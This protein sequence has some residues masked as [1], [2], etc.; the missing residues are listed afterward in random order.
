MVP[1][2]W[3]PNEIGATVQ[4]LAKYFGQRGGQITVIIF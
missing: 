4:E 3:M 1:D 2:N